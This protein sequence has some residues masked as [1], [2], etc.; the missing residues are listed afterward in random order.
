MSSFPNNGD[1][2]PPFTIF[3][4]LT[5]NQRLPKPLLR[6]HP[7]FEHPFGAEKKKTP[8]ICDGTSIEMWGAGKKRMFKP[9]WK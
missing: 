8:R 7:G 5:S 9:P 4:W 2:D 1:D 3:R 6:L